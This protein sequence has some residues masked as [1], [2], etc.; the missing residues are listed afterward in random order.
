MSVER[1]G[2]GLALA[3]SSMAGMLGFT[4]RLAD[5]PSGTGRDDII[6]YSESQGRVLVSVAPAHKDEFEKLFRGLPLGRIGS[7]T[8]GDGIE[9]TGT[10]GNTVVRTGVRRLMSAYK[11]LFKEF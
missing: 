10:G 4:V 2:L 1:G 3:K 6:L 5:V 8:A 9:I 7:V 11:G